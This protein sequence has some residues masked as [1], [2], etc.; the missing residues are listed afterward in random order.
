MNCP[1]CKGLMTDTWFQ[2]F[3]DDTG[4]NYFKAWR[5]MTCGE[6]LDPVIMRNRTVRPPEATQRRRRKARSRAY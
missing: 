3:Q 1:R 4:Q 6:V 2:D 5:C